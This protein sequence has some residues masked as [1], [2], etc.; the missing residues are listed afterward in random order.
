MRSERA[1][2]ELGQICVFKSSLPR[3]SMMT[4]RERQANTAVHKEEDQC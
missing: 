1:K 4:G 2:E 3:M